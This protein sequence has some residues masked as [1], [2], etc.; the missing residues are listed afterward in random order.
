MIYQLLAGIRVAISLGLHHDL[1]ASLSNL[2]IRYAIGFPRLENDSRFQIAFLSAQ[3]VQE[4]VEP[5][6][7]MPVQ[8]F[9]EEHGV[10][11]ID[12]LPLLVSL[13]IM[14]IHSDPP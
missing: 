10:G 13:K 4:T 3:T 7:G 14:N 9:Q 6:A 2:G 5:V 8:T 1:Q 11:G 12:V